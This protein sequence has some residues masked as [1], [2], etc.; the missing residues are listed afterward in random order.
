LSCLLLVSAAVETHAQAVVTGFVRDSAGRSLA[1]V[2]VALDGSK[3]KTRT[4]SL[5]R[6]SLTA[7]IGAYTLFFRMS[8]FMERS[9]SVTL[10]A[11][12]TLLFDARLARI[13]TARA[14]A[15]RASVVAARVPPT[16]ATAMVQPPAPAATDSFRTAPTTPRTGQSDLAGTSW[17]LVRI[18]SMGDSTFTPADSAQYTIAFASDGKASMRLDCNTGSATWRSEAPGQLTFGPVALTRAICP[19]PLLHDRFVRDM[20]FVRTYVLRDGRLS[21]ATVADGAI[22]EF[23]PPSR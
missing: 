18:R 20:P 6:Y 14:P 15:P 17:R 8:G 12:D 9:K 16:V 2:E 10:T 19:D 21:V 3:A 4:D 23:E 13:E 11:P 22:Y 1:D 5:G 7:P